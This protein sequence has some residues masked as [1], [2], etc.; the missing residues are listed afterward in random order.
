[1]LVTPAPCRLIYG[2][3]L[4]V[5]SINIIKVIL[6]RGK[7]GSGRSKDHP[8]Q[9]VQAKAIRTIVRELKPTQRAARGRGDSLK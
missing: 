4:A 8:D 5:I 1:M 7:S 2:S 3:R 6:R 9:W